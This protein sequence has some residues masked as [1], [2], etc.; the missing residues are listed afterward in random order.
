MKK[1]LLQYGAN[2]RKL[3]AENHSEARKKAVALFNVPVKN[4]GHVHV[5]DIT[6]YKPFEVK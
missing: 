2:S 1:Y 4:R 5:T 6:Q 3:M